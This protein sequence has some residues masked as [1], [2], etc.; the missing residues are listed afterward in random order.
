MTSYVFLR[1]AIQYTI[2]HSG[3]YAGH[4]DSAAGLNSGSSTT[5][6]ALHSS[7]SP[8]PPLTLRGPTVHR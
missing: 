7:V 4:S 8:A 1:T 5:C 3:M 6:P 2:W